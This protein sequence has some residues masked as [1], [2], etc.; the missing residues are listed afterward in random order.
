MISLFALLSPYF[1]PLVPFFGASRC[2]QSKE[3]SPFVGFVA[4]LSLDVVASS[5]GVF[6]RDLVSYLSGPGTFSA[7]FGAGGREIIGS[8]YGGAS[9]DDPP[10]SPTSVSAELDNG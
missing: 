9:R 2:E 7:S 5:L 1:S 4:G 6:L 8:G 10:V 3:Y